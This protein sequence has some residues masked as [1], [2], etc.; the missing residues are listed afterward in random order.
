[1]TAALIVAGMLVGIAAIAQPF[2]PHA[3]PASP[4]INAILVTATIVMSFVTAFL[5]F[6]QYFVA[7][8]LPLAL[9]GTAFLY[10]AA[11]GVPYLAGYSDVLSHRGLLDNAQASTYLWLFWHAGFVL[12]VLAYAITSSRTSPLLNEAETRD[13]ALWCVFSVVVAVPFLTFV[14]AARNLLPALGSHGSYAL[15]GTYGLA[16]I[17]VGLCGAVLIATLA[18]T[19]GR[20]ILNLWLCVAL[21][22]SLLDVLLATFGERSYSVGWYISRIHNLLSSAIVLGVFLHELTAFSAHHARLAAFDAL[23][24]LPN[25]RTLDQRLAGLVGDRRRRTDAFSVLM[26]DIDHFKMFNDKYGHATGD[27]GLRAVAVAIKKCLSRAPD[28][29]ARYGGEEFCVVLPDTDRHGALTMG[30]KIRTAVEKLHVPHASG[31]IRVTVSIG[32]V[33]VNAGKRMSHD[34]TEILMIADRALY[35]AKASGRNR[36]V[37]A[38]QLAAVRSGAASA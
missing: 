13:G 27:E 31:P 2:A 4:Q 1:L 23:T 18:I 26:I 21:F 6:A 29:A 22:A 3:L 20:T 25:R 30:E 7:R 10:A 34:V 5:I 8:Q 35:T 33:S 32:C 14:S 12:L 37:E 19:R 15:I 16:P 9:L 28:L 17:L 38:Q 11:I 24:G 36:V